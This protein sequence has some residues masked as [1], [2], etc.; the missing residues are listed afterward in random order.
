M[1]LRRTPLTLRALAL[2]AV[3]GCCV[4]SLII[5]A[6][7]SAGQA[8]G[9]LPTPTPRP[10]TATP[11]PSATPEPTRTPVPTQ[12]PDPTRT[13][14]PTAA[15]IATQ[16]SIGVRPQGGACPSEAPIKGNVRDR[17]PDKGAKIYHLPGGASYDVT[18]PERCFA[19]EADAQ[20]AGY[21]R[22]ER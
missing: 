14:N 16:A 7:Q 3:A 8:L 12:T 2:Y 4:L 10:P 21:R 13:P 15:A 6:M 17:E 19:S 20:A 22:S 9:I 18:E 11:R 5:G 1:K